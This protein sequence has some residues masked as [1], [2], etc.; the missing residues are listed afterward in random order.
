MPPRTFTV[1]EEKSMPGSKA[2]NGM[3]SVMVGAN[4]AGDFKLMPMLIIISKILGSLRIV[5]NLL[6]LCSINGN[7]WKKIPF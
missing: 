3:L 6:W 2:S 4:A 7:N 1:R 5:L